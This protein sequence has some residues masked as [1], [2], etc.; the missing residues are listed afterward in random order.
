MNNDTY[1]PEF[2]EGQKPTEEEQQEIR[3]KLLAVARHL[4]A[5]HDLYVSVCQGNL[6]IKCGYMWD[7][8]EDHDP[9]K[10]P[11]HRSLEDILYD[12]EMGIENLRVKSPE[13]TPYNDNGNGWNGGYN[14]EF[15]HK[16]MQ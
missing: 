3:Q 5:Y 2:L 14:W 10:N 16:K 13:K 4:K 11:M 1:Y 12:P 9:I 8:W 6:Q 15:H 7:R